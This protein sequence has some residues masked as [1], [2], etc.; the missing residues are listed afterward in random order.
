MDLEV[1]W[2]VARV[3]DMDATLSILAGQNLSEF[4]DVPAATM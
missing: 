3:R 4:A 2:R 1:G